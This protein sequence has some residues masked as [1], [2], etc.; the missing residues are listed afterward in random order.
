[1]SVPRWVLRAST[2]VVLLLVACIVAASAQGTPPAPQLGGGDP[3]PLAPPCE[4]DCIWITP[5]GGTVTHP[6]TTSGV[7]YTFNV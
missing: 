7:Q 3:A 1:M 4:V 6:P 2:L 5:D